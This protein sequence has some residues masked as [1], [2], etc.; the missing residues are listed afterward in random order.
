MKKATIHLSGGKDFI[1]TAK[2]ISKERMY[3]DKIFLDGEPVKNLFITYDQIM[4]GG[5]LNF[6][7]TDAGE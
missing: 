7:M 6:E 4:N 1:I 3:T 5:N 2:N